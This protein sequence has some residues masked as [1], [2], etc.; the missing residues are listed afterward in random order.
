[1][2]EFTAEAQRT[3]SSSEDASR[4]A[5]CELATGHRQLVTDIGGKT[6]VRQ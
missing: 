6:C 4:C 1:V 5:I 3:Q 2:N